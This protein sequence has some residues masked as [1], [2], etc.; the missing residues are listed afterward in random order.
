MFFTC[1]E[2]LHSSM[3]Q[4]ATLLFGSFFNFM[5]C[6][7]AMLIVEN[8]VATKTDGKC[9]NVLWFCVKNADSY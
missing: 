7:H 4:L 3:L 6:C 2:T 1:I 9:P 5:A 8:F